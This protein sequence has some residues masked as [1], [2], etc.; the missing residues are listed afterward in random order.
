MPVT[1]FSHSENPPFLS[2]LS[3]PFFYSILARS[4]DVPSFPLILNFVKR[5]Q[6]FVYRA[7]HKDNREFILKNVNLTIWETAWKDILAILE[8]SKYSITKDINPFTVRHA[9]YME[10]FSRSESIISVLAG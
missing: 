9:P 6:E 10:D 7:E 5:L 8:L 1:L 3:F 4:F 2:D